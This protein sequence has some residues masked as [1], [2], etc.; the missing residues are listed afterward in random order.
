M[1]Q[2][3]TIKNT[4]T[5]NSHLQSGHR[6]R[7]RALGGCAGTLPRREMGGGLKQA[8]ESRCD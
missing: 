4:L 6:R 1:D 7:L 2:P 5:S 3:L 8:D